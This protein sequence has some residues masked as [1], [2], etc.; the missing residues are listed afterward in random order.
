MV[1]RK[2]YVIIGII[3]FVISCFCYFSWTSTPLRTGRLVVD[4]YNNTW[5]PIRDATITYEKADV[6][7]SV[8]EIRPQERIILITP[9]N[10]F[11]K[12]LKTQ[13]FI[14]HNG[15]QYTLLGEYHTL[16]GDRYNA[17]V[18]QSVRAS[19][20]KKEVKITKLDGFLNFKGSLNVKPYF[21]IFD[22]DNK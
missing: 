12:P 10:V 13:V 7:I 8:P 14:N 17:D 11:D 20:W 22:L 16:S 5:E 9:S 4:L 19:F 21:R 18:Q 15:Q 1:K 6:V 3:V 2:I